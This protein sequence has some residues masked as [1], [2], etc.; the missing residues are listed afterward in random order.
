[1]K[2]EDFMEVISAPNRRN[3]F[4]FKGGQQVW[5]AKRGTEIESIV[6]RVVG[7]T[8]KTDGQRMVVE[9]DILV[10]LKEEKK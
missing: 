7:Q 1:M 9:P 5:V 3:V 2:V 10:Y 6:I 8:D 4:F